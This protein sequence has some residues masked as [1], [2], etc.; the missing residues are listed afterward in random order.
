MYTAVAAK[1]LTVILLFLNSVKKAKFRNGAMIN[2]PTRGHDKKYVHRLS[3][4]IAL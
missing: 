3:C 1:E 4:L 2:D